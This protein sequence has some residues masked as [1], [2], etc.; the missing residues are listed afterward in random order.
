MR[1]FCKGKEVVKSMSQK[2]HINIHGN[3]DKCNAE[4]V[5]SCPRRRNGPHFDSVDDAYEWIERRTKAE[6]EASRLGLKKSATL[7]VDRDL[8][9]HSVAQ[10]DK[11]GANIAQ[12]ISSRQKLD[13]KV[14]EIY[15]RLPK[16]TQEEKDKRRAIY[17]QLIQYRVETSQLASV[18]SDAGYQQAY[19]DRHGMSR[20][21]YA[22]ITQSFEPNT[23]DWLMSR[24]MS[25]GGSEVSALID[26]HLR[27]NPSASM[28]A[29]FNKVFDYKGV[30]A[31]KQHDI[32]EGESDDNAYYEIGR[33]WEDSIRSHYAK[34]HPEKQVIN[35]KSQYI[36]R[37][38]FQ[39][40]NVD[41][42]IQDKKTGEQE[43]I[44]EI[45]TSIQGAG[46]TQQPPRGYRDQALYYLDATGLDRAVFVVKIGENEYREYSIDRDEELRP[47]TGVTMREYVDNYL[48]KEAK[49][50]GLW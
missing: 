40:I 34:S 5:S 21:G 38:P 48:A 35:T 43:A 36:G 25:I 26:Y 11:V 46:W 4:D 18:L 37:Y 6:Q 23:D 17:D 33:N 7:N 30:N 14:W 12:E 20:L 39:R 15:D 16:R 29:R 47:G 32:V 45:K 19:E 24:R 22:K 27:D 3:P 10:S 2:V 13:S 28:T 44:L 31:P 9:V 1:P 42:L 8:L 49:A 50:R 41:G